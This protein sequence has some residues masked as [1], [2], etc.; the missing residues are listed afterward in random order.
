MN[1]VNQIESV[2]YYIAHHHCQSLCTKKEAF[3]M[4]NYVYSQWQE[5]VSSLQN[6][7]IPIVQ[8]K[9]PLTSEQRR[10]MELAV[11]NYAK[12]YLQGIKE[13]E[14]DEDLPNIIIS[15]SRKMRNQIEMISSSN[16]N[17]LKRNLRNRNEIKPLE[18]IRKEFDFF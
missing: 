10:K 17:D 1:I 11:Q 3:I 9:T 15:E 16:P 6:I 4:V 14:K 18:I 7:E 13:V 8:I 12:K 2:Y 5:K